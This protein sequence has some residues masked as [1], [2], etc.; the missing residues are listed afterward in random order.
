MV[1]KKGNGIFILVVSL[2]VIVGGGVAFLLYK[3]AKAKDKQA[4]DEAKTDEVVVETPSA[5]FPK[6]DTPKS[7]SPKSNSP[8]SNSPKSDSPKSDTTSPSTNKN[9]FKSANE[10]KK[11]Q[12]WILKYHETDGKFGKGSATPVGSAD[13]IWGKKSAN[14]WNKYGK[15]YTDVTKPKSKFSSYG[16]FVETKDNFSK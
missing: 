13:G 12:N 6:S 7:N 4:I 15:R 3:K 5:E 1:A 10:L 9:P 16:Q 14:A 2:I 8:K 11:F